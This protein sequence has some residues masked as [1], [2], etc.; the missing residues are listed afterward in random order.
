MLSDAL[1]YARIG[2]GQ[3]SIGACELAHAPQPRQ[4]LV[5][6]N[7]RHAERVGDVLLGEREVECL[8]LDKAQCLGTLV[9]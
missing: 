5:G 8:I 6:V 1:K 7:E 2:Q 4:G 3:R 9:Q